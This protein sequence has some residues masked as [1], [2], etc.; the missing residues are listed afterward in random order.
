M[1]LSNKSQYM[2]KC[3]ASLLLQ[4]NKNCQLQQ[5]KKKKKQ[6]AISMKIFFNS[7]LLCRFLLAN[8]CCSQGLHS[9]C[10]DVL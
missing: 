4:I 8:N 10:M 9:D 5:K 3:Q 6:K 7:E 1:I 2:R